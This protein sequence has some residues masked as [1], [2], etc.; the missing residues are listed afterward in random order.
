MRESPKAQS[1]RTEVKT[2]KEDLRPRGRTQ[3]ARS[4]P[5]RVSRANE[6]DVGREDSRQ[7]E[8]FPLW[9]GSSGVPSFCPTLVGG[10]SGAGGEETRVTHFLI[11]PGSVGEKGQ[12]VRKKQKAG[13]P[14][15]AGQSSEWVPAGNGAVLEGRGEALL[16]LEFHTQPQN[17]SAVQGADS[18]R[19]S[20]FLEVKRTFTPAHWKNAPKEDDNEK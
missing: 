7:A 12:I 4:P 10:L 2:W 1:T 17:V 14:R 18:K 8:H 3:K 13:W 20:N 15:P 19:V 11:P 9:K 6:G 16:H 5:D